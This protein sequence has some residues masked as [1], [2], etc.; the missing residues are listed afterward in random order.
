MIPG[1]TEIP[2]DIQAD[3]KQLFPM[4]EWSNRSLILPPTVEKSAF[5]QKEE[6]EAYI[7]GR[8]DERAKSWSDEDMLKA[9]KGGLCV[10]GGV[11]PSTK[12]IE[13]WLD[14]YKNKK[15]HF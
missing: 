13:N 6:Y 15:Q 3:A 7:Q 1:N 5:G 4:Y 8:I 10:T 14:E 12:L 9:F 11:G 2:A